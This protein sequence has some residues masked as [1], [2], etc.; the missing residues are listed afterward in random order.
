MTVAEYI[1]ELQK[2]PPDMLVIYC[3][4]DNEYGDSYS[5]AEGPKMALF[6]KPDIYGSV[7]E[8]HYTESEEV[9]KAR[10][11]TEQALLG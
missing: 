5:V 7:H 9:A 8:K 6:S 3:E 4:E 1:Q 10:G 2:F 11:L